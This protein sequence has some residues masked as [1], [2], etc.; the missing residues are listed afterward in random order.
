[1]NNSKEWV[2]RFEQLTG[3]KPTAAEFSLGKESDFD[4]NQLPSLLGMEAA[5]ATSGIE[6]EPVASEQAVTPAVEE[7]QPEQAV[8]DEPVAE[9]ASQ[10]EAE[11]PLPTTEP[12][13]N[14]DQLAQVQEQAAFVQNPADFQ[15]AGLQATNPQATLGQAGAQGQ[16]PQQG[17]VAQPG[18]QDQAFPGYQKPGFPG[19]T[20]PTKG[21]STLVTLILPIIIMVLAVLF[22]ILSFT[23]LGVVF[24]ILSVFVVIGAVVVLVLALKSNKKV[25]SFVALGVSVLGLLVSIG[26]AVVSTINLSQESSS[27]VSK[28]NDDD[29]SDEDSDSSVPDDSTDVEDYQSESS[30]FDWDIEAVTEV[31]V[32]KDKVSDVIDAHGKAREVT[33]SGKTMTMRYQKSE[34]DYEINVTITFSKAYDSSW[35]VNSISGSF[36]A[37]DIE[38]SGDSY[39]SDWTKA[40]YDALKE[41]DYDTGENGTAWN[42]IKDKHPKP[43]EAY[44]TI[45]KYSSDDDFVYGLEVSYID[46]DAPDDKLDYLSLDFVSTEG[47]KNYKLTHKYGTG[48][49]ISED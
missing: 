19:Q 36:E 4:V 17:P 38:T 49:G 37:E 41:G 1:M 22:A 15:Q 40:D 29:D 33:I 14:P 24:A 25:L 18:F 16:M 26:G 35:V 21:S 31:N 48:A 23:K 13:E 32:G 27:Q 44:Y 8:A 9:Q 46:Y 3:R 42:D 12:V 2:E 28:S 39:T 10:V 11:N 7:S 45:S 34:D 47:D 30:S 20:E 6:Q 5:E 43:N